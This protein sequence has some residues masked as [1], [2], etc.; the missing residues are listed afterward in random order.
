MPERRPRIA[1]RSDR[2]HALRVVVGL[3]VPG[4]ALIAMDRPALL[5]YAVF[6][7]FTGM[8]GR[9]DARGMRLL[10]QSQGA[11]LLLGGT[12]IGVLLAQRHASP[13]AVTLAATGFA[14]V[15]S[16]LADFFALRPEGPFYGIFALGAIASVPADLLSPLAAWL[17]AAGGAAVAIGIGLVR[18][19]AHPSTARRP[20][21]IAIR[22][23]RVRLRPAAIL[24]AVRYATAVAV[25]G[26]LARLV[27]L[28]HVNWAIAGAAVTLA[29][30]DLNGRFW[31][32]V[33]RIVGTVAGLAMTAALLAA[34][35]GPRSLAV[36]VIV[37]LFPAERFMAVNYALALTFFTPMIMLMT[38]L[39]APIG[40]RELVE[41]RA[42]GTL[43]GV[44]CGVVVTYVIRDRRVVAGATH[45]G[46]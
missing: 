45:N 19:D 14:I 39:A 23:Q 9:T 1:D 43:L 42:L 35:L 16:L 26:S 30:A 6:G 11:L 12:G 10:H 4:V 40:V 8:Y 31:R 46:L 32:G 34:G 13:A 38:E 7:S 37:L 29:A 3:A 24:H 21:L 28:A 44:L 22:E 20:A 2:S 17:I 18:P 36:I 41:S 5:I 15:G 25:A 27:G 33:H